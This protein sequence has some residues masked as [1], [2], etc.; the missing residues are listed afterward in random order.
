MASTTEESHARGLLSS[1]RAHAE[2]AVELLCADAR[3]RDSVPPPLRPA[4]AA[5]ID[6][7]HLFLVFSSLKDKA[8]RDKSF[9]ERVY[10]ALRT[11]FLESEARRLVRLK[12]ELAGVPEG[13]R[14]WEDLGAE[15]DPLEAYYG[16]FD[17]GCETLDDSPFGVVARRVSDRFFREDAARVAY[18]LVLSI[19]LDTGDR[20]TREVDRI[21]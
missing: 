7:F 2:R 9:F 12:D 8:H 13:K 5:E 1:S 19:A 11:M 21:D 4:I 18:D 20:L 10:E 6:R 17:N 14:I 15:R 3:L 16:S